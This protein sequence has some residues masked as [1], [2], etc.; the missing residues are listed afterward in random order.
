MYIV[1]EIQTNPDG[2]VATLP[3]IIKATREEAESSYHSILSYAAVSALPMHAAI[4]MTNE[5]REL[6]H[7]AYTHQEQAE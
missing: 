5:G 2:T 7:Q 4:L 3:P 1:L 6:M